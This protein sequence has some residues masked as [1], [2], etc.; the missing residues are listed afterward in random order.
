[1]KIAISTDNEYVSAHFGRCPS[2]TILDIND[3]KIVNK[4][5]IENPGHH[6][7]F[8]PQ[9]LAEKKVEIIIAGGMGQRAQE[10]FY[11]QNIKTILGITGT[12]DELIDQLIKGDLQGGESLCM[13][14]AGKGYGVDKT[15]CTHSNA[16]G[17]EEACQRKEEVVGDIQE[18]ICVTSEGNTLTA[19]V[20]PRFGRCSYYIFV[21]PVTLKFEAIQNP[22][23]NATGGAGIQAG[24]FIV[25]KMVNALVTGNVGP[26]ASRVLEAA[27]IKVFCNASGTINEAIEQYKK[28]LLETVIGPTVSSHF[29]MR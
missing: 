19:N 7:G 16:E 8:L 20:D 2:F 10:L 23:K 27:G 14:G 21:N 26:N 15:V 22:Y 5:V 9:F 24:Q 11:E 25:D 12:I 3:N 28:G 13:P 29:G 6:P 17:K 4:E 1:M 18:L